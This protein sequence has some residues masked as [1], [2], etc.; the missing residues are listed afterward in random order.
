MTHEFVPIGI[1]GGT[2]QQFTGKF[3][4]NGYAI[5]GLSIAT[6]YEKA[7]L[8]AHISTSA[9][10]QRLTLNNATINGSYSYVGAIAGQNDGLITRCVVNN[11]KITNNSTATGASTGLVAGCENGAANANGSVTRG[12][13]KTSA[14]GEILAKGN[15]GGILGRLN[16]GIIQACWSAAVINGNGGAAAGGIVGRVDTNAKG[17][18]AESY[19]ISRF[20]SLANTT[21]GLIG[22]YSVATDSEDFAVYGLYFN[23]EL[24]SGNAVGSGS[25][26]NAYGVNAVTTAEMKAG[27]TTYVLAQNTTTAVKIMWHFAENVWYTETGIYPV[28][29]DNSSSIPSITIY[30]S[31]DDETGRP[32]NPDTTEPVVV[33]PTD[34]STS[35][36]NI[37][38]QIAE[39]PAKTYAITSDIDLGG[40]TVAQIPS[41][42]G[43]LTSAG[44]NTY[45]I[46]NFKVVVS[47]TFGGLFQRLTGVITNINFKDVVVTG[48]AT[49]AVGGLV[50][51]VGGTN[52]SGQIINVGLDNFDIDVTTKYLGGVVGEY[53]GTLLGD[54]RIIRSSV[55][56]LSTISGC[57]TGGLIGHNVAPV[58]FA[59]NANKEYGLI[60]TDCEVK[61][62]NM[63]GGAVGFAEN[64]VSSAKVTNTDT[65]Y[66]ISGEGISGSDR[67]CVG[68]IVGK[69]LSTLRLSKAT[70][71]R[72]VASRGGLGA[73]YFI[74]IGGVAGSAL[75]E[76]YIFNNIVDEE[77]SIKSSGSHIYAGGIVGWLNGGEANNNFNYGSVDIGYNIKAFAGG[78][79]G[80]NQGVVTKSANMGSVY[81]TY[82][83]GIVAK[84]E[85]TSSMG[86][87]SEEGLRRLGTGVVKECY[88]SKGDPSETDSYA[89][90]A[91][92]NTLRGV[93]VGGICAIM[94]YG[95]ISNCFARSYLET[96]TM[97]NDVKS[98]C[99]I[100][101]GE[102][103]GLVAKLPGST[104]KYGLIENCISGCKFDE[105]NIFNAVN[106]YE[107]VSPIFSSGSRETGTI[108]NCAVDT[109]VPNASS[110]QNMWTGL[111]NWISGGNSSGSVIVKLSASD[112]M[113]ASSYSS[114]CPSTTWYTI[115]GSFPILRCFR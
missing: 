49:D 109:S 53:D 72:V 87:I 23:S 97:N 90:I 52:G 1:I 101:S 62:F 35:T 5:N 113:Q 13:T 93:V 82:A 88:C 98:D 74:T 2:I 64:A 103:A 92:T 41:F 26:V 47:G 8:F 115:D 108:L 102:K 6:N 43:Y 58:G 77:T 38:E 78:V 107:T 76:A 59:S 16:S 83:G 10:V 9:T 36:K 111:V 22:I 94:E 89:Y 60:A 79:V 39:A 44:N 104:T 73:D 68:G 11:A 51:R 21:G 30:G 95:Y 29:C 14:K 75:K 100:S 69:A 46:R 7:G 3:N 27:T 67:L 57:A 32:L 66:V 48:S 61:G 42:D 18:L 45:T 31:I 12:I 34:P 25:V 85:S 105:G 86:S 56:N 106:K 37:F 63:V 33:D 91:E 96:G 55:N 84:N 50:G 17:N 15:I 114:V 40:V 24:F 28:I 70:N 19:S 20:T 110:A 65:E 81:G 71:L 54:A 112:V 80:L 4:G 99:G